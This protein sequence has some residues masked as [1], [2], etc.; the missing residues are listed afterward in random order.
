[1]NNTLSMKFD[2][3]NESKKSGKQFYFADA[4]SNM[5]ENFT[6]KNALKQMQFLKSLGLTVEDRT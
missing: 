2:T 6:Y 3:S 1:M 5:S 4:G